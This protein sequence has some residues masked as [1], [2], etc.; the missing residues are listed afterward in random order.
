MS[1]L[2]FAFR[3]LLKNPGFTAVAV[4]TLALGI[5]TNT[6]I[7]SL[8]HAAL[9]RELPFPEAHQLTVVWAANP[10]KPGLTQVPPA[11]ADISQ[12][13][14][15][16]KSFARFAA[17]APR[18]AD[19]ADGGDPE[20]VGAAG[21]TAGFFE[22]LGVT[23]LHG[24]TLMAQEESFGGPPVALIS[25]GLWQ[26][27]FGG[28]LAVLGKGISIGGDRRIVIGILGP[29]FDFPRGAEWPAFFPLAGRTE[30]WLPL[31]FKA[32]DDG[33]GWS[34]WQSRDERGVAAIARL[35]PGASLRQAQ[36]EL[37]AFAAKEAKAHADTH[38]GWTLKVIP[39]SE[40]LAGKSSKSLLILFAAAGLLLLIACVNVANLLLARGIGRQHEMAVR[41]A[42]GAGRRR[43]MQQLL[44]EGLLLATLGGG[45]ALL[46]AE[47]SLKIFLVLN[48]ATTSRLDEASLDPM[49]LG[50]TAFVAL[51]TS[52]VFGLVPAFRTSRF[53]LQKSLNESGRSTE[54]SVRERLRGRLVATEVALALV[55]LTTAGLM[56]RSFLRVLAVQPGFRPD[57]VL[58][59]DVQL[60]AARYKDDAANV[61]FF[62]QLTERLEALPETVAAG[63]ISY[64]PLGGGENMGRFTVEGEPPTSAG[65]TPSAERRWVT[66]GYFATMGIP[67]R[68]GRVFTLRDSTEQPKV[69]VINE[70]MGRQFFGSRDPLGR[71]LKAG[72]AWRTV[73]GVVSDVKSASLESTV[74]P[75]IYLPY[76]QDPW[77][78]MTMVLHAKGDPLALVSAVRSELKQVDP[79]LPA[80][81]MRTM[82]QVM[83]NARSVR[84]LNTSLLAFFAV[85]ALLLTLIGL[86]GVVAFL[87]NRRRREIGIRMAL[88]AQPR[89]VVALVVQE[90]MRPVAVGSIVGVAGSLAASRLVASQLYGVTSTDP[91]TFASIIALLIVTGLVAC[92]FPAR[93][94]TRVLPMAALRYE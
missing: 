58:A 45:L 37:D 12:W 86:Y 51:A 39:L 75:Q 91:F 53:D 16:S 63:A 47:A 60:Q 11:N 88:G 55:L 49:V 69:V 83:S 36:A 7:F 74:R 70:T 43:L 2:K 80:A 87:V 14:E 76:A 5:G 56:I 26:R 9:L 81:K 21:V 65:N 52:A 62:Q 30:V 13:R 85:A 15:Q 29:E 50:F 38:K 54:G 46:V 72:G 34:N 40:Q 18:S 20:R 10:L 3:Q 33:T 27:R 84:R 28:D 41:A 77:P 35:K 61:R 82:K 31:G 71:R 59:F 4:L 6:A 19:L 67:I 17:F 22:T 42:L 79:L 8:I 57:S 92:W 66:P 32:A 23:P 90:G 64:L 94:A 93:R 48:P 68:Q 89:N 78:P 25:Y 1:D 24:R 73:V 44:T